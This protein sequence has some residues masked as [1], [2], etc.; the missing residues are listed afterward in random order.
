MAVQVCTRM[1]QVV[2]PVCCS[3]SVGIA[4]PSRPSLVILSAGGACSVP[5]EVLE[6]HLA[7]EP[8]TP[9]EE[10]GAVHED[11][12]VAVPKRVALQVGGSVP[13]RAIPTSASCWR[14]RPRTIQP[15]LATVQGVRFIA[16]GWNHTVAVTDEEVFA[17]GCNTHGQLGTRS[18]RSSSLPSEVV[19]LQGHGVGQVSCGAEHTLFACHDGT[20]LGCG[21]TQHGQLPL[22][23]T[24]DPP[25][26]SAG[27]P[28]HSMCIATPSLLRLGFLRG[29]HSARLA[30]VSQIVA[31]GRCSAF[32]TRASG[33]LPEATQ[34]RL[35]E[36]LQSA[37][38]SAAEAPNIESEA[39]VRPIAAAV[40]RIFG[41][42]AAISAAFGIKDKVCSCG[43][44]VMSCHARQ[45]LEQRELLPASFAALLL[46]VGL[47][48]QRLV[49]MQQA[50]TALEPRAAPRN[51]DPQP[52]QDTLYQV[53]HSRPAALDVMVLLFISS[54]AQGV[55]NKTCLDCAGV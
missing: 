50:I 4:Q 55:T 27:E 54:C 2:G 24:A 17:W 36:R 42:A 32:L 35:W 8:G 5:Q 20:V 3:L 51:S 37:V 26:V 48:V 31:A 13:K 15:L 30:E 41:S 49:D 53:G 18:F 10:L 19:D 7:A 11:N 47:D 44:T 23:D 12:R 21:S 39:Y 22:A 45:E 33:E 16:A 40:E 28:A 25:A 6:S 43:A 46:Q 14:G 29:T 1:A 9:V 38:A 52:T 34:P